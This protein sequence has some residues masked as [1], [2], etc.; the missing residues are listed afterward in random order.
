[1]TERP[2]VIHCP[3]WGEPGCALAPRAF[4]MGLATSRVPAE[5]EEALGY[6]PIYWADLG[7]DIWSHTTSSGPVVKQ[8][9][10]EAVRLLLSS[11]ARNAVANI[12]VV[13]LP[14]PGRLD[15]RSVP[16]KVRTL[17]AI[18][19][20]DDGSDI[21]LTLTV[22]RFMKLRNVGV[23]SILD[24]GCTTESALNVFAADGAMET[25]TADVLELR[26]KYRDDEWANRIYSR[27]PRFAGTLKGRLDY[28][29]NRLPESLPTRRVAII[30]AALEQARP[31][32]ETI[33]RSALEIQL[34]DYIKA[35]GGTRLSQ[36]MVSGLI[37]RFG[38]A[39]NPPCTLR[40]AAEG[41]G[42]TRERIRQVESKFMKL[43]TQA[44]GRPF[45][46]AL[47]R[48]LERLGDWAPLPASVAMARLSIEGI[49]G[50]EFSIESVLSAAEFLGFEPTVELINTEGDR[51][52][53]KAA[54]S[55]SSKKALRLF[56]L[57]VRS[58]AGRGIASMTEVQA[59]LIEQGHEV[60]VEVI[61][62]L[63]PVVPGI[64]VLDDWFW[65]LVS[66][67]NGRN[68]I[69]NLTYKMLSVT[70]PLSLQSLREGMRRNERYRG[71]SAPPPLTVLKAFY[72][73]R[74]DFNVDELGRVT[75]VRKV[76]PAS[77]LTSVETQMMQIL[78]T[79]PNALMDRN[80]FVEACHAAGINLATV[81]L[82][83]SY[84]PCLERVAPN[85]WAPRGTSVSPAVLEEFR[86]EHGWRNTPS[87]DVETGWSHDGL[88]WWTFRVNGVLLAAAGAA[89]VPSS[90]R[91]ILGRDY[92]CFADGGQPCGVIHASG[93][94]PFVWG[95]SGFFSLVGVDVGDFVRTSFDIANRRASLEVGGSELLESDVPVMSDS[96]HLAK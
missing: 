55:S 19:W 49:A 50:R 35:L 59:D 6:G 15:M 27:D 12:P 53:V 86:R 36:V 44:Q 32:A 28:P 18:R 79:A 72:R 3:T 66:G 67:D 89:T 69:V 9:V 68:K 52:V 61:R 16:L 11:G 5:L 8:A 33:V 65:D 57:K 70:S 34:A 75:A 20:V 47:E 91:A 42:V 30:E 45:M 17:N 62:A 14:L 29:L 41:V 90:I 81:S 13:G 25:T 71:R 4:R 39:G 77:F 37:A 85:V 78:R 48:A 82:W 76:A 2:S 56:L 43:Q 22:D 74:H 93:D 94:S 23:V 60:S 24:Y 58:H 31:L 38:F 92:D 87:N 51:V 1:M 64:H 26:Q 10:I 83:T 63:M 21:A 84:N 80:T 73:S 40:E 95:W 88:P 7:P 46:P 54:T 96:A